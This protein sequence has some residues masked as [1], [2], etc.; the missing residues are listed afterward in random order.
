MTYHLPRH[1]VY[2][3]HSIVEGT[4][5]QKLV[6]N[7]EDLKIL[8]NINL[9]AYVLENFVMIGNSQYYIDSHILSKVSGLK[10]D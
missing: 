2:L 3:N 8:Q 7:Y 9:I 5:K 10:I 1:L 6:I 4:Y